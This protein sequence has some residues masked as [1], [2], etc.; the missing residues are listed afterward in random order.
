[1]SELCPNGRSERQGPRAVVNRGVGRTLVIAPINAFWPL[2]L[3]L[4]PL[5][6]PVQS[7]CKITA[8]VDKKILNSYIFLIHIICSPIVKKPAPYGAGFL[9]IYRSTRTQRSIRV[10]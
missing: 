2:S 3:L 7:E 8:E 1:M 4:Q 5:I 6:P 10:M 9:L